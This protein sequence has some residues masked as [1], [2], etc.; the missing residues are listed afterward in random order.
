[1]VESL[2]RASLLATAASVAAILAMTLTPVALD[3]RG[4]CLFGVPCALGHA[5]AFG[6]LGASLAGVFATSGFARRSP[7]R[8]LSMLFL[9]LWI[10]AA[11]TEL[12]QREVGRDASLADWVADM[13]GAI[14][15]L[16][17]GGFALRAFLGQRLATPVPA[18]ASVPVSTRGTSRRPARRRR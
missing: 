17:L 2:R 7:R 3:G 18:P 4:G 14:A 9:A 11:L 16:L 6:V 13:G 15:G 1:V 5:L 10:F 12:A 8:A